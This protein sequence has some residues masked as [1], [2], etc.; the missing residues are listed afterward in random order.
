MRI[1]IDVD[2]S[3]P[4]WLRRITL[5]AGTPILLAT[6]G[7]VYA[8][9]SVP[10]DFRDGAVLSANELNENFG[11]LERGV[12][13]AAPPGAIMSYLGSDAP[14]GWLI[15]DGSLID[16]DTVHEYAALVHHLRG[17]GDS[18]QGATSTQAYLPDLRGL[19][20]RGQDRGSGR[21]PDPG[22]DAIGRVQG[23][24]FFDHTH[25][26]AVHVVGITGS[27]TALAEGRQDEGGN[28]TMIGTNPFQV[29]GS[30]QGGPETRPVNA[31]VLYIVKY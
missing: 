25:E 23:H 27:E 19:F 8:Q 13:E 31:T 5:Y 16:A 9:L 15:A 17:L 12:N 24:A 6:A 18:F 22:D 21:N 2:P 26:F 30:P 4:R 3:F 10:H 28:N 1:T 11:E 29:R 20:L 14:P 7:A